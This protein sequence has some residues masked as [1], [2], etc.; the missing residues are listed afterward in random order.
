MN[1]ILVGFMASGKTAVGRR[2]AQRLGYSFIDT[3]RYI[4]DQLGRTI[5]QVFASEGEPYFRDLETRLARRLRALSNHIIATGGG[6]V[7]TPGNM[8][9]LKAAG[10]VIFL[11]ADPEEI[12][13]RLARDTRR[14]LVQGQDV[15]E[16]VTSLLP[17][18]MP[19]YE[20]AHQSIATAGMSV[21]QVAGE[22][23]RH[24]NREEAAPEAH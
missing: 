11:N 3:D 8:A 16:R 2:L 7:V 4:E 23:L 17:Q 15:R 5:T 12:I 6:M 9:L 24:L 14:P 20:Q 21:N 13:K 18:R 22:I 19:L 1:L 10:K